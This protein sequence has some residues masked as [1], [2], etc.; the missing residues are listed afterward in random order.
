MLAPGHVED[1]HKCDEI[2]L[3]GHNDILFKLRP[4]TIII[5][6]SVPYLKDEVRCKAEEK[7]SKLPNNGLLFLVE[8]T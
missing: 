5:A 1:G 7:E 4:V 3:D 8:V 6:C 2:V